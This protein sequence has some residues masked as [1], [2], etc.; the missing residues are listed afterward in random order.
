LGLRMG[1]V[2][3]Q[4]SRGRPSAEYR[5]FT[6][7]MLLNTS[8]RFCR[9]C[10]SLYLL[11]IL[12]RR[13]IQHTSTLC[14]QLGPPAAVCMRSRS[15]MQLTTRHVDSRASS[16]TVTHCWRDGPTAAVATAAHQSRCPCAQVM[17]IQSRGPPHTAAHQ[18]GGIN[19]NCKQALPWHSV[20]IQVTVI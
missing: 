10:A 13:C 7:C 17:N 2:F 4:R 20:C 11:L 1:W 5:C 15:S 14:C 6:I 3:V 9:C 16:C 8:H 12:R 19:C 18:A